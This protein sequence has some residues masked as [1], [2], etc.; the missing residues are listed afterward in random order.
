MLF[1]VIIFYIFPY[2]LILPLGFLAPS[3]NIKTLRLLF[4]ILLLPACF[5]AI[6]R[7]SIGVDTPTYEG[8][9]FDI[10]NDNEAGVEYGFQLIVNLLSILTHNSSYILRTISFLICILFYFIF[11]RS[12]TGI[13]IF[14]LL[15]F[16]IFFYDFTM[17]SVRYGLAF[18][19]TSMGYYLYLK[20][21]PIKS[22]VLIVSSIF[23]HASSLIIIFFYLIRKKSLILFVLGVLLM[24][25]FYF[26][27]YEHLSFKYYTY[28]QYAS[29]NWYSG[30]YR[31]I[32][33]LALLMVLRLLSTISNF[34]VLTIF[35]G[36]L[37]FILISTYSYAG[38]RMLGALL[39]YLAC[40]LALLAHSN[41]N[42]LEIK[43]SKLLIFLFSLGMIEFSNFMR[44]IISSDGSGDG[45]FLPFYFI[46]QID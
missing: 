20:I 9:I 7:G 12:K 10:I 26:I 35:L 28:I 19:I 14:S 45:S 34:E 24:L 13:Q 27:M 36:L 43:N 1:D 46:W 39:Y 33:I 29:P 40:R 30:I 5:I 3:L 23:F 8:I 15:I 11:S 32:T 18:L 42:I 25:A 4:F 37:I 6:Y 17:N 44:I 16:P 31:V 22:I 21:K 41:E 2:F 38:L